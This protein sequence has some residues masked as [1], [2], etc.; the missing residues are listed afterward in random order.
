M[1]ANGRH[2]GRPPASPLRIVPPVPDHADATASGSY[3]ALNG[4]LET[5]GALLAPRTYAVAVD[6]AARRFS[7][8]SERTRG[9]IDRRA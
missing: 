2:N 6:L 9:W 3:A 7:A 4:L 8:E 1:N 5:F